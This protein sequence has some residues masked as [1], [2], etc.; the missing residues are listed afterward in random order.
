LKC[1]GFSFVLQLFHGCCAPVGTG[2]QETL[3]AH[4]RSTLLISDG[5][6]I[7]LDY[8]A[9]FLQIVPV[10]TRKPIDDPHPRMQMP[11]VPRILPASS[12]RR[13]SNE[14]T[15]VRRPSRHGSRTRLR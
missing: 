13:L 15:H 8:A 3:E 6:L 1:R 7:S 11:V 2:L 10:I 5:P 12:K 9:I 14:K 4:D